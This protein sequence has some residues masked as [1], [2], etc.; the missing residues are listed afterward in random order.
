MKRIATLLA[1]AALAVTTVTAC[2]SDDKKATKNPTGGAATA[3]KGAE[4]TSTPAPDT[5]ADDAP[6][7]AGVKVPDTFPAGVPLP[8][9]ATVTF[10]ASAEPGQPEFWRLDLESSDDT[11]TM[12]NAYRAALEDAGFRIDAFSVNGVGSS[13]SVNGNATSDQWSVVVVGSDSDGDGKGGLGLSV[14]PVA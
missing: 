7:D 11:A 3:D 9:G 14:R 10:A 13:A 8:D 2:S 5:K 4:D 6:A 12:A 1:V